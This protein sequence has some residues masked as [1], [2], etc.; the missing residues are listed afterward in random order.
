MTVIKDEY[1]S[2][3]ITL[4]DMLPIGFLKKSRYTGEKREMRFL[5]EKAEISD[6]TESGREEDIKKVTRLRVCVWPE[7][8]AYEYT[9]DSLKRDMYFDLSDEGIKEAVKWL[10]ERLPEFDRSRSLF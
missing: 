5:L 1:I 3:D 4:H 9:D 2:D 6:E 8:Y 7:P 10:N